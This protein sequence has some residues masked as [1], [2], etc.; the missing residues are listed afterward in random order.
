MKQEE[1]KKLVLENGLTITDLID[2]VIDLNGIIGVGLITLGTD[3]NE[4][5]I[6]KIRKKP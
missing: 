6:S 4:Y 3:L 1:I 5:C 2:A